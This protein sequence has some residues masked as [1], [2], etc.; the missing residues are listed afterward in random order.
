MK[1]EQGDTA[2]FRIYTDGS[3]YKGG[4][5]AAAAIY[6][7]DDTKPLQTLHVHL[8]PKD[9]HSVYES[10]AVGLV[11]AA[12]LIKTNARRWVGWDAISVFTDCQSVLT[13]AYRAKPGPGQYLFDEFRRLMDTLPGQDEE[14]PITLRWISAHSGVEGNEHVDEQAKKAAEGYSTPPMWL[15][16]ALR[17]KLPASKSSIL[18]GAKRRRKEGWREAWNKSPRKG[19]MD[20]IDPTFPPKGFVETTDQLSRRESSLLI[21]M[22]TGHLPLNTYLHRRK[23]AKSP[24]CEHCPQTRETL[25]HVL[26]DCKQYRKQR[27]KLRRALGWRGMTDPASELT[28]D[29][30]I[31]AVL[32]FIRE[33]ERL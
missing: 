2:E 13:T 23:F 19:R 12:W 30:K 25:N 16:P 15:P 7:G 27:H 28:D 5:G 33:T 8:G 11:L 6:Q 21:Q 9:R 20:K 14:A 10:E 17:K 32:A 26:R 31:K 22:R 24:N 3:G 18:Q 1:N 4:I 29:D